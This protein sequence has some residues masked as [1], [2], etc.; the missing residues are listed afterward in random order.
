MITKIKKMVTA[1]KAEGDKKVEEEEEED[2]VEREEVHPKKH[3]KTWKRL[4]TS[5]STT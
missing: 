2:K 5:P 1:A 4:T 3:S